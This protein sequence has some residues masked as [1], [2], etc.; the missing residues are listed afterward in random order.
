MRLAH[1]GLTNFR[2]YR[3]LDLSLPPGVILLVGDNAQGKT[4]LLESIYYLATSRS[5]RASSDR[6]LIHWAA[7]DEPLPFSRVTGDVARADGRVQI[8]IVV[9]QPPGASQTSR[10]EKRVKVDGVTRR[11]LDLLGQLNVVLFSPDDVELVSGG[12]TVRR[13][14]LDATLCQIDPR[15]CHA[16]AQYRKVLA[17]RNSLLRRIQDGLA[18][19]DELGPWNDWLVEHGALI[20]ARR[21]GLLR[22][23]E[24]WGSQTH[25]DLTGGRDPLRVVYRP[26]ALVSQSDKPSS[27]EAADSA[28][29]L[30]SGDNLTVET[31][32][33]LFRTRLTQRL[34]AEI[35]RGQTLVGPHRDDYQLSAGPVDLHLYGSRGQQRTAALALKLAETEAMRAAT[36]EWPVLLLDDVMSEL[37]AP[38]R[39]YVAAR[40]AAHQQT[41]ATATDW[42]DFSADLQAQALRLRVEL[43]TVRVEDE[44]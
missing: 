3:R 26:S 35:A 41:L 32:A 7:G 10:L 24:T 30:L 27:R 18:R 20:T 12:P 15:Y 39:A 31:V 8:E 23:L 33:A 14:Y 38:R 36:G 17:Q 21:H 19:R 4:A 5:P 6:E 29:A 1:L 42:S 28:A 25:H 34:V 13:R 2:T 44:E 37:D 40:M 16:L 9:V 22:Q 43:G 11:A